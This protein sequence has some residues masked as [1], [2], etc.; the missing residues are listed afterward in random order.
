ML[1]NNKRCK[2]PTVNP[3]VQAIFVDTLVT[4]IFKYMLQVKDSK[5][6][7]NTN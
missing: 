6:I 3:K 7:T 4:N 1:E 5:K 2:Q